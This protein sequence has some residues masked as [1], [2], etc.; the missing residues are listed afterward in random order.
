MLESFRYICKDL[1]F[2]LSSS[3][4]LIKGYQQIVHKSSLVYIWEKIEGGRYQGQI[5]KRR[6]YGKLRWVALIQ[7][8]KFEE[9]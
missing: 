3:Y 2:N 4:L 6:E 8:K 7:S 9:V 1:L 5:A